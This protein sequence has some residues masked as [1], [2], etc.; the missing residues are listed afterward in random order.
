MKQLATRSGR[1]PSDYHYTG[2]PGFCHRSGVEL[3][4]GDLERLMKISTFASRGVAARCSA[5]LPLGTALEY[6]PP[7]AL[8]HAAVEARSDEISALFV[9]S[10][11]T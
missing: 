5:S 9:V 6:A 2:R 10:L 4:G 8:P 3:L 7:Q 11:L 1:M